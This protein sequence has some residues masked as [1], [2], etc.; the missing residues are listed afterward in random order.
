[1]LE[2]S[3]VNVSINPKEPLEDDLDD[4]RKIL[5]ERYAECA[6]EYFLVVKLIFNP[7]HKEINIFTSTDL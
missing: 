4:V 3:M 1:M 5:R 6:R 2:M 7:S